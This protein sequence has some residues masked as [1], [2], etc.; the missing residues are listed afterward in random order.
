MLHAEV[1]DQSDLVLR[2][3]EQM[4]RLRG[5]KHFHWMRVKRDDDWSAVCR[6]GVLSGGGNDSLMAAMH[7]IENSDREENGAA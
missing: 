4:G 1:A 2:S 6:M 3:S 7:T 5:P